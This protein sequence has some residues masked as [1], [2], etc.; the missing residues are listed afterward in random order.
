MLQPLP[1]LRSLLLRFVLAGGLVLGIGGTWATAIIAPMVPL[2]GRAVSAATADFTISGVSLDRHG[3]QPNVVFRANLRHVELVGGHFVYPLGAEADP[4]G[5][6]QITLT[7]GGI[8]QYPL[9]LLIVV[10][11]WPASMAG[12]ALR[13][14]LAAP[15]AAVLILLH[16]TVTVLAELWFPIHDDIVPGE[17]W[18]LLACSRLLMG[19]GGL[20]LALAMA[21]LAIGLAFRL[22]GWLRRRVVPSHKRQDAFT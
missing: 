8:L 20:V 6:Y 3:E 2:L 17:F 1:P 19:G 5:W 14:L 9:L 15:L 18:P 4:A 12:V 16:V 21:M 10:L 7:T 22:E 11:A 13:G